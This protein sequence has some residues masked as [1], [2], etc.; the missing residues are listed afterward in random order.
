ML[1]TLTDEEWR[2]AR[3]E[4]LGLKEDPLSYRLIRAIFILAP[5]IWLSTGRPRGSF[6]A[7]AV[8]R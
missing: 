8:W 7:G 3:L 5:S 4:R 6:H 2:L 1:Y